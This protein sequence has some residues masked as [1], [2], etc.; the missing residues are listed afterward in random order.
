MEFFGTNRKNLEVA[1]KS[2][3]GFQ[4]SVSGS[5]PSLLVSLQCANDFTAPNPFGTR[6]ANAT[7]EAWGRPRAALAGKKPGVVR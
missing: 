3:F 4:N 1:G 6:V 7:T 5:K 2:A